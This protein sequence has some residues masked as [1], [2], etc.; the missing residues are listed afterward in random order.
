MAEL[1]D[2]RVSGTRAARC[3]SSSLLSGTNYLP[4]DMQADTL[5]NDPTDDTVTSQFFTHTQ[6]H[7]YA[8]FPGKVLFFM[9]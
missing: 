7:R 4:R 5:D 6:Q 9:L 8:P 3:R 1:V 2:A